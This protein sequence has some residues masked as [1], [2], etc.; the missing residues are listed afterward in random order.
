L[1][2]TGDL[3]CWLPNGKVK[4]VGR[5]DHQ[6]KLRGFRIELGEIEAAAQSV[7]GVTASAALVHGQRLVL[8]VSPASVAIADLQ[9]VLR[10]KLPAY[11]V[12]QRIV[13]LGQ[14]PVT[15]IGKVD[16]RALSELATPAWTD[17][18]VAHSIPPDSTLGQ[19]V[20]CVA[21]VLSMPNDAIDPTQS[22]FSVGGDSVSAIRLMAQC[23]KRGWSVAVPDVFSAISMAELAQVIESRQPTPPVDA[24]A[25]PLR[26]PFTATERWYLRT[27]AQRPHGLW[28]SAVTCLSSDTTLEALK[29]WI[30]SLA[31]TRES[32]SRQLDMAHNAWRQLPRVTPVTLGS[33]ATVQLCN[34]CTTTDQVLERVEQER[35]KLQ[36]DTRPL[37]HLTLFALGNDVKVVAL[38]AH[39]LLVGPHE[40]PSILHSLGQAF[41]SSALLVP[42]L[43]HSIPTHQPLAQCTLSAPA[44]QPLLDIVSSQAQPQYL[45]AVVLGCLAYAWSIHVPDAAL[46]VL[47]EQSQQ[48]PGPVSGHRTAKSCMP[49]PA[50]GTP[51]LA[52]AIDLAKQ[53]VYGQL[54]TNAPSDDTPLAGNNG[55]V[56][57]LYHAVAGASAHLAEQHPP[58]L[59]TLPYH[60]TLGHAEGYAY[61]AMAT[62]SDDGLA[63]MVTGSPA[64]TTESVLQA[65][66]DAWQQALAQY[67]SN[68]LGT[69]DALSLSDYPLLPIDRAQ[70]HTL[71]HEVKTTLNLTDCSIADMLPTSS[72]QDGF[73]VNTLKDPSAYMVQM[74]FHM[75][76]PLDAGRYRQCW[77]QVSQRHSILR[78]K[79]VTTDLIP[80][81]AAVQVV[82]PSMDIAWSYEADHQL[83]NDDKEQQYL[84]QDRQ[85]GF[86]FDGS[87]LLRL[88]LFKINDAG[89]LLFF[90]HHHALLDGWSLNIVLDEVMALY[91]D[92]PLAPVV[93]YSSYLGHLTRQPADA[94]QR[95]W[96]ELLHEVAPTPDLQLPS[97]RP[98]SQ[99]TTVEPYAAHDRQLQYPLSDIHAFCQALGI[100]LNNLLRGLWALLLHRYLGATDEVTFGALVSGRNVPVPGI[101]DMVGLCINTVPF[102]ARLNSEQPLHDW[103][104]GIHRVSGEMMAHEH[105]NLGY[106]Q[107]WASVPTDTPL[108]QSLLVYD[109]YRQSQNDVDEQVLRM[110]SLGGLNATEYPLTAGFYDRDNELHLALAYKT[111]KYDD[112]YA[113]LLCAYLDACLSR[114]IESTPDTPLAHVQQLP[115]SEHEMIV[116]WSQGVV[117]TLDPACALLPDLFM[118]SL[119]RCPH[120]IALESGNQQWT[121]AQ[122]HQQALAIAQWLVA[123]QVQPG[124][125]VA[126]VF[127]RSPCFLFAMLAV[128]LVG[129]VYVPLEATVAT[130]RIC[131]ILEELGKP[132]TLL[133]SYSEPLADALRSVVSLIG[134]CDT[135]FTQEASALAPALRPPPRQPQD[136][137]YIIFTSG[138]TG[139]PKGVQIRH[140]SVV[141]ILIHLA[142]TMELGPNCR[143]LQLLNIAFDGCLVEIFTTF[144]AGGAVVLSQG[145]LVEDLHRVNTCGLTPTLL[146]T[147]DSRTYPGV[148]KVACGGEALSWAVACDWSAGRQLFDGYGPTEV[149]IISHFQRV[150]L[151]ESI[152]LGRISP[153]TQCYL[154]NEKRQHVP[155]GIAGEICVA[156]IGVS[157]GYLNRPDLTAKA[158]IDNPFGSG[159][160]YLTGDLGCWL[161]NGKIKYLGRKDHQVKLRGFRIELGEIESTAQTLDTVSMCAA[162]VKDRQLVLYVSPADV[163]Q[164]LLRAV[165]VAKLPAYMVP[166]HIIRLE[167]LPLTRIGKVDRR[168]LQ[169]LALPELPVDQEI[170]PSTYSP[171]FAVLR[172]TLAA[173]L[174]IDANHIQPS[175]SFFR[176]GG[177]SISAIQF[178]AKCK[179]H[180]LAVT[181]SQVLKHPILEQLEQHVEWLAGPSTP[182]L[183]TVDDP[184]GPLPLTAIQRW[185]LQDA[186]HGNFN[187]FNQSFSLQCREGLT[188]ERVR[189]AL[190]ALVSHHDGLRTRFE[191]DSQSGQWRAEVVPMADDLRA[192]VRLEQVALAPSQVDGYVAQLQASLSIATALN[193]ACAL[194]TV[195]GTQ[196]LFMTVHHL[197]V[198]LVSWRIIM[199]DMET[200][201]TSGS[202]LPKTLS[203]RQWAHQAYDYAQTLPSDAWPTYDPVD[204]IPLD[205]QPLPANAPAAAS[206]QVETVSLGLATTAQ[207]F[208]QAGPIACT[209]PQEFMVAALSLALEAALGVKSFELALESHGRHP[210][211]DQLDVSRTVGWFTNM[212]SVPFH[213]PQSA[214]VGDNHAFDVLRHTKQRIR[215]MPDHGMPYGLLKYTKAHAEPA[216]TANGLPPGGQQ[217]VFNYLGR[218]DQLA[219]ADAFWR[220]HDL[221]LRASHDSGSDGPPFSQAFVATCDHS[222]DTGLTLYLGYST[223]QHSPATAAAIARHWQAAVA[224]LVG[225]AIAAAAPCFAPIDFPLLHATERELD[226]LVVSDLSKLPTPLANIETVY[227]CLPLQRG[228]LQAL[229]HDP[230]AYVV[231]L[232]RTIRGPLDVQQFQWAWQQ[233]IDR[234]PILR[235]CFVLQPHA[236]TLGM[237]Q[238]VLKSW[239][240]AWTIGDWTSDS[241]AEIEA[242]YLKSDIAQGFDTAQPMVRLALFKVAENAHRFVLTMHHAAIDGWSMALLFAELL[243]CYCKEKLASPG[244]YQDMAGYVAATGPAAAQEYWHRQ[245][246]A[247]AAPSYLPSPH[248]GS[249]AEAAHRHAP[250]N[251]ATHVAIVGNVGSISDFAQQHSITTST[252]LRA[253]LAILLERY[254]DQPR[255][256]FGV[257]VSGRN[258]PVDRVESIVGPCINTIPCHAEITA[259]TTLTALLATM[260]AD[261]IQAVPYE[262]FPLT[263]IRSCTSI[264]PSQALFNTLL[265]YENY[266]ASN[267]SSSCP[268]EFVWQAGVQNTE[269]PLTILASADESELCLHFSYRKDVFP[270]AYMEQVATHFTALLRSMVS[271]AGDAPVC[272]L[273]ML[274]A[275]ETRC[276]LHA[277]ASN[278]CEFE[279]SYAHQFFVEQAR[280]RPGAIAVRSKDAKHTYRQVDAMASNIALQLSQVAPIGPDR[281]VA[282]VADNSVELIVGQLA[283]WKAGCAFVVIDPRYPVARKQFILSDARCIAALG[284][285]TAVADV[286]ADTPTIVLGSLDA[287]SRQPAEFVPAV[288]APLHLAWLIYTSGSTGQPKG[289]MIE[290]G[291]AANHFQGAGNVLRLTTDT[292]KPTVFTPTFDVSISEIWATLSFGGTIVI[293]DRDYINVFSQGDRVCCTPSLLS[294]FEPAQFP[295]LTHITLTGEP[296]PQAL[297]DQ[298]APQAELVNWYGPTEVTVVSH[299][300]RLRANSVP[301]IGRPL[302]NA[303]AYILDA[304]LRPVPVGAVGELHIGG[305]GV[306]RGYLNLPELTAAKFIANPYG[307]GR[308]FKSGDLARW[309]P[310]GRVE[311]LGRR[312]NQV[313]VRGYRVELDEVANALAKCDGVKQACVVVQDSQLIGYVSPKDVDTPAVTAL[314]KTLLPHY[315]VPAALVPLP[316]LPLTAVGKVDKRALPRHSFAQQAAAA[317]AG[318]RTPMEDCLIRLVAQVL[319]MAQER[320]SPHHTFFELGGDSLSAIRLV[321]LCRGQ[322]LALAMADITRSRTVADLAALLKADLAPSASEPY[323]V[324]SGP[325]R[326][327]PIQHDFFRT[328]YPWPQ[329]YLTPV[330]LESAT[331]Y[332]QAVWTSVFADLISYHDMLRFRV[333]VADHHPPSMGVIEPRLATEQVLRFAEAASDAEL[334]A[335]LSEVSGGVNY[336]A[337]PICQFCIVTLGQRQVVLG[338]VHHLV[339]DLVS[340]AIL[341]NDLELLLQRQALPAKTLS[342]QAWADKLYTLAQ[343]LD[344]GA[345][346]VPERSLPVPLDYP[347]AP[348]LKTHE[349]AQTELVTVDGPLLHRFDQFTRQQDVAPAELLMAA[350][351][352]AYERCFQQPSV[353]VAFES[354][355]RSIPGQDCDVTHTLGWFVGHHYLSLA[356][357]TGQTPHDVL[358]HT[359]TLVRGLPVNGFNLFLAKYLK[360][361]D[362]PEQRARFDIQPQVAFHYSANALTALS[363]EVPLLVKRNAL[364]KDHIADLA[365]NSHP[366]RLVVSCLRQTGQLAINLT[367]YSNQLKHATVQHLGLAIQ[368]A[369]QTF[370]GE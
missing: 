246:H 23:T 105:A 283:V 314:A 37:M 201:L 254:T 9:P 4:I 138:T 126:L 79:F 354:H 135:I 226:G 74:A 190:T 119:A 302:P 34:G 265:V 350:F 67:Q 18:T 207:L 102:R 284:A 289:V 339:V 110:R 128:L 285:P 11:M 161:P 44:V 317:T 258:A 205:Y 335:I 176:L 134:Y 282:I 242:E 251:Y 85:H 247:I 219:A 344:V 198:D 129:G 361:L 48:G 36:G 312:D 58:S 87:P 51:S 203:F 233:V 262:Q 22:F 341:S 297:V 319:G 50:Q 253:T 337:G 259:G 73:I 2:L 311:C 215:A 35:L 278:P 195:S 92:Q 91:H 316:A 137:A 175:S 272:Q 12:P 169:A 8:F 353:T 97:T 178:S 333:P 309:L 148:T 363:A 188:L 338:A 84:A 370:I 232:V 277:F 364:F 224:Q 348:L 248:S 345:V 177:D 146:A 160:L 55:I 210:W 7:P 358:A 98:P 144:Y 66:L 330:V 15:A 270:R 349:F 162:I 290:H 40:W 47:H 193:A 307:P 218:F 28:A 268:I 99:P 300:A 328:N 189:G 78:T 356:K 94:A 303:T 125:R 243:A 72:L 17:T 315:M 173:V 237:L 366:Y 154:L 228:M 213:L 13:T 93:Q 120:A 185:F 222:L 305:A 235:T 20:A 301:V 230:T 332:S 77:Q 96:Q 104:R 187:H 365:P 256:L 212:Y 236:H 45:D 252:L 181:V 29:R 221:P 196:V 42:A 241:G 287:L 19:L 331:V 121:Y 322:H 156:G 369:V 286:S 227:P 291:S 260:Q 27:Y 208:E 164:T 200:L 62:V 106:I 359:Q 24:M 327:T 308:L 103:L 355:G 186:S 180:G 306:A 114:V 115:E 3:G 351:V 64:Q 147:L 111:D 158:F 33:M 217:V 231:Q 68:V 182:Q 100:T 184:I 127:T 150:C 141:N 69:V 139:K 165:L 31:H 225:Q 89:H 5:Q 279:A 299:Y 109:K 362:C 347:D 174:A 59:P 112:A 275:V 39:Q 1:Y 81:H 320:V 163:D 170:D 179:R 263:D 43:S 204:P 75:D 65:L 257:T 143:F 197:V 155:I 261:S 131:G 368:E 108:F 101:D 293:T 113:S 171:I 90:T 56:S 82:L 53:V 157:N 123:R 10:H 281:I 88:A 57:A 140:E 52:Q 206:H 194:L 313:K 324:A 249:P 244:S 342:Y 357:R 116:G 167:Q 271:A 352:W 336:H 266:P 220:S 21:S 130:E 229:L 166:E 245:L 321:T 209:E 274:D 360:E 136:L 334:L 214:G 124:D 149:T 145:N 38:T 71:M 276:L 191:R 151:N 133:E 60:S 216:V 296:A 70:F 280:K 46:E 83:L 340:V 63:L 318:P 294:A 132:A 49:V 199:E 288:P 95:F 273:S 26:S 234:H 153:N 346:A 326:L 269:Y 240:P 159:K 80:G 255:I 14:L 168:A 41:S 107:Q 172:D 329:A 192:H 211:S 239:S 122:V 30:A 267:S 183:A 54:S 61:E 325:V 304:Q 32:L 76:G 142:Q 25:E 202:L 86:A 323:P 298:W 117:K 310:D 16:R 264:D 118:N 367:Y 152:A 223:Q 238:A 6:V 295:N 250:D 292:A 343:A